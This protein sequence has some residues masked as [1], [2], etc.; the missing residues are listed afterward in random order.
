[1]IKKG[2]KDLLKSD[3]NVIL[4]CP[5]SDMRKVFIFL[6]IQVLSFDGRHLSSRPRPANFLCFPFMM[7]SSFYLLREIASNLPFEDINSFFIFFLPYSIY[8]HS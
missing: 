7:L 1:M 4:S 2:E 8:E 3:I 6:R 5:A